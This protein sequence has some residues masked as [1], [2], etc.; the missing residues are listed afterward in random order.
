MGILLG[1][2]T[3]LT[4]GGSDFLARFTTERMGTLRTLLYM[5]LI[6]FILGWAAGDTSRTA[7]AGN[8]GPGEFWPAASMR[9][10]RS[11]F[12]VRSKSE[13]WPSWRHSLRVIRR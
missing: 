7:P 5:Q 12:T 1:I 6:G 8:R 13:K 9:S 11:A 3:A 2:L 10:P 4:W